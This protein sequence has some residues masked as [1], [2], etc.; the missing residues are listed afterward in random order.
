MMPVTALTYYRVRCDSEDCKQY[1]NVA[2]ADTDDL[3]R[4]LRRL[5]WLLSD[6]DETGCPA[7]SGI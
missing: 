7:H 1:L 3:R 2:A 5:K 4:V 6:E